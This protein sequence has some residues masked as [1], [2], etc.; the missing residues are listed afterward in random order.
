ME[1]DA[2]DGNADESPSVSSCMPWARANLG[3]AAADRTFRRG[4]LEAALP[5]FRFRKPAMKEVV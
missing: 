5:W 4:F 2:G 3:T 1:A